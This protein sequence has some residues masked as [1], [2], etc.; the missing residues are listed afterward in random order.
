M[1]SKDISGKTLEDIGISVLLI[2]L[3]SATI[4]DS[5]GGEF[6]F[7][8][9]LVMT[10]V[11]F[12]AVLLAAIRVTNIP[13]IIAGI[14]TV[15][16]IAYKLYQMFAQGGIIE[17]LSYLWIAI[18]GLAVLGMALFS[19][20]IQR[21]Q[22]DNN[23][24][25]K[26]V[27]DLI[28]IDP[29]TGFYN[30]RSMYMDIQTQISYSER[31]NTYISLMI[32]RPRYRKELKDVLNKEQYEKVIVTFSKIV[33][34]TV[35]LEDRVYSLDSDGTVGVLLTCDRQGAKLV[36]K[37]I[38]TKIDNTNA[39]DNIAKKPI[40]MEIQLGFLEY[41]KEYNRDAI[42]FKSLVE[43]EVAYDI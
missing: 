36:E 22:R 31:N 9:N 8:E 28:M 32:I 7:T 13:A 39:F 3:F 11:T 33:Y 2:A 25:S 21:L 29:L 27:E 42:K 35:R 23:V 6:L 30:L 17:G 16:Y 41:K 24:L 10:I 43:E 20:G 40:R 5:L 19:K 34:E 26:Q 38:R 14:A 12:V 37:R 1:N 15:S 18:P 4:V